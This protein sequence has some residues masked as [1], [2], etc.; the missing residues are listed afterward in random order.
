MNDDWGYDPR[1]NQSSERVLSD[2]GEQ[3]HVHEILGS[4][5][6]A[7][8]GDEPHNHRFAA[9]SGE[10]VMVPGG[11]VH[12]LETR[13]DFYDDHFHTI[14]GTS[15]RNIQVGSNRHVHF[16]RGTTSTQDGHSHQFRASALIENP[17]D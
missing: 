11:H 14:S 2:P 9:I 3:R 16:L 7:N 17:I 1:G 15:G 8:E 4:V 12:A 5:M 13:T 10:A 6:V